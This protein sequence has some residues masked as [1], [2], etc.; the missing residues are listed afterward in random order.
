[1][2]N[3]TRDKL[4]IA[5]A[6]LLHEIVEK[7][8]SLFDFDHDDVDALWMAITKATAEHH[9]EAKERDE[10]LT[11]ALEAA[12]IL[13]NIHNGNMLV[14]IMPREVVADLQMHLKALEETT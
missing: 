13:R 1:M 6:I 11:K 4:L 10:H 9:R 7:N 14:G 12:E 8:S 5:M 2:T 3:Q